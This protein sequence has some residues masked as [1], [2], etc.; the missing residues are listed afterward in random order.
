MQRQDFYR[1]FEERHRGDRKLI[2]ERL[3]VYVP[4]IMPLKTVYATCNVFDCGCGRGEW[5]E[6]ATESGFLA[7][8][9]DM[10]DGMLQACQERGMSVEKCDAI[11]ALKSLPDESQV[12]ISAFHLIEHISFDM[13]QALVHEAFRVL[14]PAG[15]LI[16]ETPNP[17]NFWVSAVNFYLD[18]THLKPVPPE[19]LSFLTDYQGFVRS[20][21]LRLQE[22]KGLADSQKISLLQVLEGIS[23]DYSV[24]AQKNAAEDILQQFS[25]CFEKDYGINIHNLA[26]RFELRMVLSDQRSELALERSQEADQRSELALERAVRAEQEAQR[27]FNY[28]Q[29]LQNELQ[30]VYASESWRLTKPLRM[31]G[32]E[33]RRISRKVVDVSKTIITPTLVILTRYVRNKP[34]VKVFAKRILSHFPKIDARL[35][36]FA[37]EIHPEQARSA[38]S[39]TGLPSLTPRAKEIYSAIQKVIISQQKTKKDRS[40]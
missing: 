7:A 5:I 16:L 34:A 19:L 37:A 30:A 23:P 14:K 40:G 32:R 4:F 21:I 31:A 9:C 2:K 10:D 39:Y 13:L 26:E 36:R 20:K 28:A 18:P 24:V 1:A 15:V 22:A 33:A 11:A 3:Q 17:E 27:L 29:S 12:V 8:G 25:T 38:C 6:L 35:R